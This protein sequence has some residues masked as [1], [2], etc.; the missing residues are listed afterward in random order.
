MSKARFGVIVFPG[1]NCDR[2]CYY[3]LKDLL[4]VKVDYIWHQ[5]EKPKGFDCLILPGGFS[6][7]D[8]LRCGAIARFSPVI[9]FVQDFAGGGGLVLGICNGFQIL[10]ECGLLPG[11]ML[12]NQGLKFIC[13][14][15]YVRVDNNQI[16]FTGAARVGQVLKLPVKHNE[17]NYYVEEETLKKMK[18]RG[19]IVLRYST[20]EGVIA[21]EANPNGALDNIAGICNERKNIFGLMP[22]PENSSEPILG[23]QDGLLIFKSILQYLEDGEFGYREGEEFRYEEGREEDLNA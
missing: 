19:Q 4:Q 8:Y 21:R 1:S 6:Y 22:H 18:R 16:P 2:D 15:V 20:K 3:V 5:E 17:G 7:G 11:A 13:Q 10:L 12:R 23:S 9:E 14:F